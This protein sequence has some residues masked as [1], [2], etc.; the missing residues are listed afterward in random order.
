MRKPVIGIPAD[1]RLLGHH[2]FHCVGEKYINAIAQAADAVPVLV[3]A[4]GEQHLQDW[5][6][7]F[8]GILFTGSPSN[9]EP[10]RYQ[11][12]PAAPGTLH[13]PERDSTT[14]PMITRAVEAGLPVFGICRG[15][16]EM[17]VAFGGSLLQKIQELPGKLDHREDGRQP[18]DVQYGPSHEVELTEGGFLYGLSG[19]RRIKVNS[20]HSQG[21]EKLGPS[22]V[23]EAK[24]DDGVVEAFRVASAPTFALAVQWHPEWKVMD[25]PFSRALFA[26]F[27]E[28]GR[29]RAARRAT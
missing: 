9:V 15:F 11:G 21:V 4:L 24:A 18:L 20:L 25:N 7:S 19:K 14:L 12:E 8:D 23:T 17:N 1:R 26:A 28:A 22:L 5:L 16:Q 13:D 29:A 27:G 2:W 6:E 3:P 10:H